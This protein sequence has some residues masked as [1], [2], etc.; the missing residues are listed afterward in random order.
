MKRHLFLLALLACSSAFATNYKWTDA[1]GNVHYTDTPPPRGVEAKTLP[2]TSP[3]GGIIKEEKPGAPMEEKPGTLTEGKP[4]GPTEGKP[5]APTEGKSAG[6]PQLLDA[7]A[8]PN[9]RDDGRAAYREFLKHSGFRA[10]AICPDGSFSTMY[11]NT[12]ANL[13]AQMQ[14]YLAEHGAAGCR[15]YA[16]NNHVV[17]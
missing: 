13:N 3:E 6:D 14:K 16:I 15:P 1:E 10:F 11:G 8:I 5:G 2:S 17:W 4:G 12:Q 7:N 9:V